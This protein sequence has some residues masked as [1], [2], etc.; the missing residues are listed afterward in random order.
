MSLRTK[1]EIAANE[2]IPLIRAKIAA[3]LKEE[4]DMSVY[5]I[6]KLIGTTPASVTNY[7]KK[8]C[9]TDWGEDVEESIRELAK[10]I[11]NGG[12]EGEIQRRLC[13]LCKR[14]LETK[15]QGR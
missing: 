14:I 13:D 3:I 9:E 10:L 2:V 7:L 6:A 8:R 12:E 15:S 4:Y 11:A 1:C 5:K